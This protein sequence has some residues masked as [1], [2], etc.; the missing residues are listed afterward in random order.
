LTP[1]QDFALFQLS[2]RKSLDNPI[3]HRFAGSNSFGSI[4]AGTVVAATP[5][6]PAKARIH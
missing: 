4:P 2:P 1:L 3:R 5:V 6:I